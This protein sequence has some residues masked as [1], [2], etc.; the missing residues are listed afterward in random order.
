MSCKDF[1]R[2]AVKTYF[3][4]VTLV[5]LAIFIIGTVFFPEASFGYVAF[6]SPLI[7]AAFCTVPFIVMYSHKE[8]TLRQI[9]VRKVIQLLCIE[10]IV[11]ILIRGSANTPDSASVTVG[12]AVAIIFVL[13]HVIEYLLDTRQ[14]SELNKALELYQ[15]AEG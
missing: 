5:C 6:A 13:T 10:V 2:T 1:I 7:I 11:F 12:I 8:L 14:A 15:K 4:I 9:I 3:I